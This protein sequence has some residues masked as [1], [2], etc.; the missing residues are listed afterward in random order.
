MSKHIKKVD[1][2]EV[3]QMIQTIAELEVDRLSFED[4]RD[5]AVYSIMREY[6]VMMVEGKMSLAELTEVYDEYMNEE[7][8][9]MD[10][11]IQQSE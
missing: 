1:D 7:Y 9:V 5:E 6:R 2:L 8:R 11:I 4:M 3:S 10:R